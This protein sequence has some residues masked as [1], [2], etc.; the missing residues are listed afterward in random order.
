MY[1][2]FQTLPLWPPAPSPSWNPRTV[3]VAPD[4]KVTATVR[5]TAVN[6]L[7]YEFVLVSDRSRTS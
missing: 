6:L 3:R 4:G 1:R 5:V 7:A 2:N